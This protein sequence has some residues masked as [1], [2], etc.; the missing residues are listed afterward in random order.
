M[1]QQTKDEPQQPAVVEEEDDWQEGPAESQD[2]LDVKHETHSAESSD[3][4]PDDVI[5]KDNEMRQEYVRKMTESYGKQLNKEIRRREG[6][7]L[8]LRNFKSDDNTD[9]LQDFLHIK[10]HRALISKDVKNVQIGD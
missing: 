3:Y 8:N 4:L 2:V 10:K 1:E 7:D 5:K 6:E 9:K